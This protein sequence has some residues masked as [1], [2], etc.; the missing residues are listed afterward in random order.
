LQEEYNEAA[1]FEKHLYTS[2]RD[3]SQ[4]GRWRDKVLSFQQL[5]YE[6]VRL[7]K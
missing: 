5:V 7:R 6:N 3:T 2:S 1:I 4:A